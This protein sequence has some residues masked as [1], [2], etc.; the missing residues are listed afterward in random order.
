M[1]VFLAWSTFK[2][3][4]SNKA[5]LRYVDRD[6][7][8]LLNYGDYE[9]SIMK[10]GSDN[11]AQ[12]D[13]ETNYKNSANKSP[14]QNIDIHKTTSI[15]KVP[16]VS[17]QKPEGSSGSIATHDWCDKTTWYNKSTRVT[18]EEMTVVPDTD[19]LQYSSAHDYWIDLCHG[20]KSDEDEISSTYLAKIY[21]NAVLLTEDEDYEINYSTGV[22][23]FESLPT[24]PVTCDYSY[25]GESTFVL[26][27]DSGKVLLIEHAELQFSTDVNLNGSYIDFEIWVYNP[28]DLPN[29]V[30]YKRKRYKNI[31]D[32]LN[33]ANLGQGT[34][35]AICGMN[36]PVVVL[37]FNY[38][39]VTP[40]Q[41][42]VGAE[43]RIRINGDQPFSGEFSTCTFYVTSMTE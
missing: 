25:A 26:K 7:F 4:I 16:I 22:V 36:N 18:G 34:I 5:A 3:Y 19:G 2:I 20:R 6:D 12:T 27:P 28:Y 42:S 10:D 23:T 41:S 40:L 29:K 30:M 9:S 39:T 38:V 11:S 15:Q 32:I 21:D 8:Y 43:L 17:I 1:K 33:S 35:P 31:K 24:G 13:F 37:P 14:I